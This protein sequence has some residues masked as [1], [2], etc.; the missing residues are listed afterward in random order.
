MPAPDPVSLLQR[1]FGYP[2]FRPGQLELV[3]GVLA[4]R[5]ALGVLP[6][7]GGK[8]VCYQVPALALDGLCLVVTPLISLMED[9]VRRAREAGL[10]AAHLSAG[11]AP[12]ERR[13]V[14]VRARGGDL[15]LLFVA[16]ERLELAGF[17][18]AL[19]P[20]RV[21]LIA[22]DE[23]HCV[24]EWGNDFRPSYRKIGRIRDRIAAP[25]IALTATATPHVRDDV[26]RS[27]RLRDPIR[28]V[29]SFDRPNLSWA[30]LPGAS[31]RRRTLA[32]YRLLRRIPGP[33]IVYAGTRR[34]VDQVR[35]DLA[36]LGVPAEAYHAGLRAEE[37]S[38]IQEAFMEGAFRV[39]V[40]TNAFGMGIDKADVRT[41]VHVQLPGTLEAYYQEAGRA[42][43]DGAPSWCVAFRGR[44]DRRLGRGFVDRGHP[45]V[46]ELGRMHRALRA[47]AGPTGVVDTTP[48]RLAARL[49][50][51]LTGDDALSRVAALER[52]GAV[53]V[54]EG[55]DGGSGPDG[56][57]TIPE[58]FQGLRMG[59]R[60]R[61]DLAVARRL[62]AV[63]RAKLRSVD[64]YAAARGCRRRSLLAY[65]GEDAP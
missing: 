34:L 17:L 62:R 6:T 19:G 7:G 57:G 27:L 11:Q 49:G 1:H 56:T 42:G 3:E 25:L 36:A 9:Q 21:G 38:R 23:A 43:R 41:V 20:D 5:D 18:D 52:S 50:R 37:R 40:A 54:L 63:A 53:R 24:S 16:P 47:M 33:A 26:T 13:A 44:G 2:G 15:R 22:V 10:A 31:T 64:R 51:G 8:S 35:D 48:D 55:P 45:P 39:V 46:R 28:V 4:G 61:A 60:S 12:R 58:G 59:V 30:V 32:A 14:L 65:F 29:R